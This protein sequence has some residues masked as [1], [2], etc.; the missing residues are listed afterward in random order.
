MGGV[1][2][3]T[4]YELHLPAKLRLGSWHFVEEA[5]FDLLCQEGATG[6]TAT[7]SG[8][9]LKGRA[10]RREELIPI[11]RPSVPGKRIWPPSLDLLN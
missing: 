10:H 5:G 11:G 3:R 2:N 4:R 8:H 7:L 1:P 6:N 9:R